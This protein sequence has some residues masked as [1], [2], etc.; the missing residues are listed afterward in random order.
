MGGSGGG[1]CLGEVSVAL[2]SVLEE[3][4]RA[5]VGGDRAR[6]ETLLGVGERRKGGMGGSGGGRC[7]GEVSVALGCVLEEVICAVVGDDRSR[8]ETLLGVVGEERRK[9]GIGGRGGG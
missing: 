9:G 6:S 4:I 8:S 2:G 7:L 1:R 3:V 5:V